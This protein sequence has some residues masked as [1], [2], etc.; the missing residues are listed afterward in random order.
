MLST[1]PDSAAD[2]ME[3][4]RLAH[5]L[6][7]ER[8]AAR[9]ARFARLLGAALV[10]ALLIRVFLV[11]PFAIPSGSMSPMLE[12]GDFVFVDKA[13]YG[14][15]MASLP[16]ST[17]LSPDE[18]DGGRLFG[19]DVKAGDVIVFVSPGGQDYVKRM[20]AEGGDRVAMRGG[21][22]VLNGRAVPCVPQGGGLCR[23]TL[24]GGASHLI[25][26]DGRGPF[27]DMPEITVPMGYYFVLGDNRDNSADSRLSRADGGVGLVPDAHVIGRASRIFFSAHE[28][29]MR[30]NRIGQAID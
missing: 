11:Q 30:W 14:W 2:R 9:L 18:A 23:E 4:E 26:S 16:L 21:Q 13:A 17:L 28:G 29:G 25:R 8:L 27:S 22:L 15:S 10:A 6:S 3:T 24:P 19:R 5:R 7:G 1:P 20:V 12:A